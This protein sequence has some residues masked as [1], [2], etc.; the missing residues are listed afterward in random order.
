MKGLIS[1]DEFDRLPMQ[2]QMHYLYCPICRFYYLY[3]DRWKHICVG[4]VH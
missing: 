2:T 3:Q 4:G 1:E